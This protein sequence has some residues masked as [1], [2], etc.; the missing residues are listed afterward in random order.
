MIR[1]CYSNQT[2]ALVSSLVAQL[3][4]PRDPLVPLDIVVP[5]RNLE[6]YL[7]LQI[8]SALGISANIRYHRLERFIARW[9][10][11]AASD[12]ALLS[13]EHLESLTLSAFLDDEWLATREV[14]PVKRYLFA[15][16][17]EDGV[18]TRRVELAIRMASLLEEY[19]YSRPEMLAAWAAG[20]EL[21][22]SRDETWQRALY[23]RVLDTRGQSRRDTRRLLTLPEALRELQRRG[24]RA[25]DAVDTPLHVFGI[26]YVARAFL[27]A[28]QALSEEREVGLYVLNPCQEFWEDVPTERR[29][30][31]AVAPERE[32][33][34]PNDTP[35]LVLWG[36]PGR[37]HVHLLGQLVD[38]FEDRF[39]APRGDSLLM[40]LQRDVLTREPAA[41]TPPRPD[42]ETCESITLLPA[43]G[44]RRELEAIADEIWRVVEAREGVRFNDIALFINGPER[45][46]YLPHVEAVFR[47]A[48]GI[49]FNV[50]DLALAGETGLGS[51][52]VEAASM[53]IDL[54]LSGFT[55][56]EVLALVT[57]PCVRA[58]V[59]DLPAE[60]WERAIDRVGAFHGIDHDDHAGTY[61]TSDLINWDQ[62]IRRMALGAF[63][64]GPQSGDPRLFAFNGERYQVDESRDD[65]ATATLGLLL[66]SLTNDVRTAL[67]QRV[68][69]TA[70]AAFFA[71]Q[72]NA[73]LIANGSREESALRRCVA[74]ARAL[75]D[76]DLHGEE[77][78][79]RVAHQLL[80]T[81]LS[82]LR[83]GR[84]EYLADGVVVSS[85]LPMRAIPFRVA[86]V[87]GLGESR[88]PAPERRDALDLRA[89]KRER[90]DV[91]PSERDKYMFLEA[92]LSARDRVVLSWV[93]RDPLTGDEIVPSVVVR[94]LTA[95]IERTYEARPLL[96]RVPLRRHEER[97][98]SLREATHEARARELGEL[99]RGDYRVELSIAEAV[100]EE[101]RLRDELAL[102]NAPRAI[103]EAPRQAL[104]ISALRR[105]LES[106]LQGWAS[107]VLGIREEDEVLPE[108]LGAKNEP[109]T[110][111]VLDSVLTLRD[112]YLTEARGEAPASQTY[113]LQTL[114]K[115]SEGRWP[116]GTLAEQRARHDEAVLAGWRRLVDATFRELTP[117]VARFGGGA[118]SGEAAL[119]F[120]EVTVSRGKK[121]IALVGRTQPLL[122]P[123]VDRRH[124][125]SLLLMA[126]SPPGGIHQETERMRVA[127]RAFLDHLMLTIS[128]GEATHRAFVIYGGD[129]ATDAS[130]TL[131]PVSRERALSYLTRLVADLHAGPHDTFAPCEAVLRRPHQFGSLTAA[132][133]LAETERVRRNHFGGSARFGP[134][135]DATRYP[136]L[137]EDQILT[138]ATARYGLFFELL[139]LG[140]A[141]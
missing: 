83:G 105:F 62:G 121:P 30:L 13:R 59:N 10:R 93:S 52:V 74:G 116:V 21:S 34:D 75:A 65:E 130:V 129:P 67:R 119:L 56:P 2:E 17:D 124:R 46:V 12:L 8:A 110:V 85:F 106:P 1:I 29:V 134:V 137:P 68:S 48:R 37:E 25:P 77:V 98:T 97:D 88:F 33:L 70:W 5:N 81:E 39:V 92:L 47:E 24:P 90:G 7:D 138:R 55:R 6:R 127:M 82:R 42:G 135:R 87:A 64:S 100:Q 141:A 132:S 3:D 58:R 114:R 139:G 22:L 23:Q 27:W 36:R 91:S 109:L 102:M 107:A 84:G 15:D 118:G 79:F 108:L 44:I 19:T 28:F 14:A 96:R 35:A 20:K 72:F 76:R 50:V 117:R 49:P 43:P 111:R 133:L 71:A 51:R 95:M 9:V 73:F 41:A 113:A 11:R 54:P 99:L 4:Q 101:P 66:R 94:Q 16:D 115:M 63:M 140:G 60:Q 40:K 86:F 89:K 32:V 31:R 61:I 104:S 18:D 26:S 123:A 128:I 136:A 126:K 69:L 45:D 112:A 53:L 80:R 120:D 125:A 131:S 122:L 103:E 38:D 57:H 78:G